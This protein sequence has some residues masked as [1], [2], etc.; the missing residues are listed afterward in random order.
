MKQKFKWQNIKYSKEITGRFGRVSNKYIW[1][2]ILTPTV[3]GFLGEPVSEHVETL[4]T[5][6]GLISWDIAA[7]VSGKLDQD[8]NLFYPYSYSL[9]RTTF[10]ALVIKRDKRKLLISAWMGNVFKSEVKSELIFKVALRDRKY[11]GTPQANDSSL[12]D[13]P[14]QGVENRIVDPKKTYA[15]VSVYGFIP[16]SKLYGF[17]IDKVFRRFLKH[18][19]AFVDQPELFLKLF[20]LAMLVKRAP[21]QGRQAIPDVSA[22]LGDKMEALAVKLGFDY[23]SASCSHY[24]V[25][26]WARSRGYVFDNDKYKD[27]LEKFDQEISKLRHSGIPIERWQESWLCVLQNLPKDKIP[28]ELKLDESLYWPQ[29]NLPDSENIWLSKAMK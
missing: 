6:K 1:Q 21:G 20:A 5:A 26:K 9:V 12:L 13:F 28:R 25:Y 14:H 11:D 3:R 8:G 2:N 18:P 7:N 10:G 19:F 29:T 23:M 17:E 27:I 22:L 15:E 24:H 4:T 16:H